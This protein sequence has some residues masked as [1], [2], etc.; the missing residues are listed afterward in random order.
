MRRVVR[1]CS[2]GHVVDRREVGR[3]YDPIDIPYR[4]VNPP[5]RTSRHA[6]ALMTGTDPRPFDGGRP[7]ADLLR[8][9]RFDVVEVPAWRLEETL[10][11]CD[12]LAANNWVT[13]PES[14]PRTAELSRLLRTQWDYGACIPS[15]RGRNSVH[16]KFEDLRTAIP[17]TPG[18]RNAAVPSPAGSPPPSPPNRPACTPSPRNYAPPAG[19]TTRKPAAISATTRLSTGPS[20]PSYPR[21]CDGWCD[22]ASAIRGCGTT[23]SPERARNAATSAAKGAGSTSKR[24]TARSATASSTPTT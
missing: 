21:S 3:R 6:F 24:S 10:L 1:V 18:P 17:T 12:Q 9:A 23:R 16:Q 15:M 5:A 11:A 7:I 14:D 22:R 20:T 19:S 8:A 4:H 13:I 2:V